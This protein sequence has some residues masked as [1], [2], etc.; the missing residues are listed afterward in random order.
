VNCIGAQI[1]SLQEMW[2]LLRT[3]VEVL[4]HGRR[5]APKFKTLFCDANMTKLYW[6]SQGSRPDTDLD[7]LP[8]DASYYPTLLD[9]TA[10][11]SAL[12]LGVDV[13]AAPLSSNTARLP[14]GG[15]TNAERVL[16]I[17]DI[18]EVGTDALC[19][20]F[21]QTYGV[22]APLCDLTPSQHLRICVRS[23]VHKCWSDP[24]SVF[25]RCA[26]TARAR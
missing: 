26:R 12:A 9:A 7:N 15:K 1:R 3:G 14:F 5:G 24:A 17:R 22:H 21:S 2:R 8:E 10:P 19:D 4:K 23:S 11:A 16:Y 18:K 13:T 6:R 25:H 20:N